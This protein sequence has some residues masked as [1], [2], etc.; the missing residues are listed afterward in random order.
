MEN[1]KLHEETLYPQETCDAYGHPV[2]SYD[3]N[4]QAGDDHSQEKQTGTRLEAH[5]VWT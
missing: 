3:A 1:N 2:L 5:Q 4:C